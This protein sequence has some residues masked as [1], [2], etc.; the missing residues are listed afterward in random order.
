MNHP[1]DKTKSCY[2]QAGFSPVGIPEAS[3]RFGFRMKDNGAPFDLAGYAVLEMVDEIEPT[4]DAVAIG[5]DPYLTV[6]AE[7]Q[8]HKPGVFETSIGMAR[9]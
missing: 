8:W 1:T 5:G 3:W 2:N 7:G 6:R 9:A 4:E